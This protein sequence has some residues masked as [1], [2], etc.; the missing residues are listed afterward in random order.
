[1]GHVALIGVMR[2]AYKALAKTL[3]GKDCLEVE[4]LD[5][6]KCYFLYTINVWI[7]FN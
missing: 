1:M 5:Y 2:N 7:R 3:G 6:I 4:G